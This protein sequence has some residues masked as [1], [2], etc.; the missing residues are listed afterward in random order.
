MGSEPEDQE[1]SAKKTRVAAE[2]FKALDTLTDHVRP[3]NMFLEVVIQVH[4]LAK[5]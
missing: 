3:L 1:A 5:K 4:L 2:Q